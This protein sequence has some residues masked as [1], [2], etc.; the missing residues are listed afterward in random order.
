MPGYDSV[1]TI[2]QNRIDKSEFFDAGLDLPD[3]LCSM[4]SRIP[5]ARPQ[6]RGILIG[7]FQ[8]GQGSLPKSAENQRPIAFRFAKTA[9][10]LGA[11]GL[12]VVGIPALSKAD[13]ASLRDSGLNWRIEI[14]FPCYFA[15]FSLLLK[16]FSL[17]MFSVFLIINAHGCWA[18][19]IFIAIFRIYSRFS[20]YFSLLLGILPSETGSYLTAHTTIQS[21]QTARFRYDAKRG[22]S[23][24]ISGHSFLGFWS[25]WAFAHFSGGFWR[26]VSASKN[27]VPGG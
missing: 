7:D 26:R 8:G 5:S 27:S 6:L 19:G 3:L 14:F 21:P 20:L 4:R 1:G 10:I 15:N 9:Q 11:G 17:L 24:G 23:A 2:D 22:V 12:K 25:L 16:F 13:C 18:S